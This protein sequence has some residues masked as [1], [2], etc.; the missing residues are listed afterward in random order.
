VVIEISLMGTV[1]T[2]IQ[3]IVSDHSF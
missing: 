3:S 1:G 2:Y